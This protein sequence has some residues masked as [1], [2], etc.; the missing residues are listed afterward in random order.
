MSGASFKAVIAMVEV[1]GAERELPSLTCHEMVRL[2]DVAVG[3][4]EVEL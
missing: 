4:S 2:E 3:L 1:T